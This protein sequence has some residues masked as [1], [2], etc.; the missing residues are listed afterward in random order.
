MDVLS[1]MEARRCNTPSCL[2]R[3]WLLTSGKLPRAK[4]RC[5]SGN[6]A[7]HLPLVSSS[8]LFSC[9]P[10]HVMSFKPSSH[11]PTN[12]PRALKSS[13]SWTVV[14]SSYPAAHPS[15]ST[16]QSADM[17]RKAAA[18]SCFRKAEAQ[19][20]RRRLPGEGQAAQSDIFF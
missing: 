8:V 5:G 2:Y 17:H 3:F 6:I 1:Q 18:V 12:C 14:A 13:S 9:T 20:L 10:G 11:L 16:N 19:C 15:S 4:L 7:S